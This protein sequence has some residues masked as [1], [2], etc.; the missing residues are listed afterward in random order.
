MKQVTIA[1]MEPPTEDT[2]ASEKMKWKSTE[3]GL[4]EVKP[5]TTSWGAANETTE[6]IGII[7]E[8]RKSEVKEL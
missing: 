7:R 3:L 8:F 1:R 5:L 2:T 4:R 6:T